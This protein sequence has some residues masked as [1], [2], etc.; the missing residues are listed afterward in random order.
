MLVLLVIV[1][2]FTLHAIQPILSYN[3]SA[4]PIGYLVPVAAAIALGSLLYFRQKGRDVA[5]FF[6]SSLF[7]LGILGTTAWGY[8][9]NLVIATT[10]HNYSLT[11][12]NSAA[13]PYGFGVG[14]IW[15]L[16]GFSLVVTYTVYMH[17]CFW[18]KVGP[19]SAD[20]NH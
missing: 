12:Y 19:P 5:A 13:S 10:D 6:A 16:I 1:N 9:P 2:L 4:Y 8:Y 7:I 3:F 15:F 17:R 20:N 11:V 14:L 18:G